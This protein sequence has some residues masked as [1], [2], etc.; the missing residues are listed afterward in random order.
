M[1]EFPLSVLHLFA[2]CCCAL[3]KQNL[4]VLSIRDYYT[5]KIQHMVPQVT[6]RKEIERNVLDV[7]Q[8]VGS[9][10][11]AAALKLLFC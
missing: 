10:I 9:K 4:L 6:V 3:S 7:A 8:F 5:G 2:R 11:Q 1:W